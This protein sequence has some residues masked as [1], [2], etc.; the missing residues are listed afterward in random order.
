MWQEEAPTM[1]DRIAL[2]DSQLGPYA[3]TV[4]L[5][6]FLRGNVCTLRQDDVGELIQ[7]IQKKQTISK[8]TIIPIEVRRTKKYQNKLTKFYRQRKTSI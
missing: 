8:L 5:K 7:F 3:H 4:S 2:F 1:G 6:Q